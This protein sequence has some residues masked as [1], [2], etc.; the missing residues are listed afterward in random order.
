MNTYERQTIRQ[1]FILWGFDRIGFTKMEEP[2][3]PYEETWRHGDGT[4]IVI[5]WTPK[6]DPGTPSI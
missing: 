3:G 5:K 2:N 6:S 1:G 4:Q